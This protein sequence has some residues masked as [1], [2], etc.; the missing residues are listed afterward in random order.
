MRCLVTKPSVNVV[1]KVVLAAPA[2]EAVLCLDPNNLRVLLG[3]Y[4]PPEMT[5]LPA[6]I[7]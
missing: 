2:N 3:G 4:F 6:A 5:N 1:L 7:E